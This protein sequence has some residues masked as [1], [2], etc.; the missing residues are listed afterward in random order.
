MPKHDLEHLAG[1][2]A[3]AERFVERGLR[4]DD[5]LFTAGQPIWSLAGFEELDWLYVQAF[6]PGAGTFGDKLKIQIGG[7]SASAI[8]LMAEIHFA[9]YLPAS[10]GV[11]ADLKRTRIDEILNWMSPPVAMPDDLAKALDQGIGGGGVGFHTYKWASISYFVRFGL[12]WKVSEQIGR[13]ARG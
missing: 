2:Y 6:D 7:G 8:Q 4:T 13:S 12:T 9:Y 11:T 10:G 3:A 5:S 1:T